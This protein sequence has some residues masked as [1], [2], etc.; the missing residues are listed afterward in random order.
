MPFELLCKYIMLTM[1]VC[2]ASYERSFSKL[3][4]S[5]DA[6][7]PLWL[8]INQG[9]LCHLALMRIERDETAKAHSDE[10]IDVFA[11]IKFRNAL[12]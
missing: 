9:R 6:S 10:I 1:A 4:W 5:F 8:T 2:I 3:K 7:G 12:F 11:S